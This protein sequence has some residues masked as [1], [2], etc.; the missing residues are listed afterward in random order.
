[1]RRTARLVSSLLFLVSSVGCQS[2]G[3]E[4]T[5]RKVAVGE[6]R[7]VRVNWDGLVPVADTTYELMPGPIDADRTVTVSVP[8]VTIRQ[9]DEVAIRWDST[10]PLIVVAVGGDHCVIDGLRVLDAT[11]AGD[12][13]AFNIRGGPDTTIRHC[14]ATGGQYAVSTDP[15]WP[16][17]ALTLEDVHAYIPVRRGFHVSGDPVILRGCSARSPA[18]EHCARIDGG[19]RAIVE[20]CNFELT[21]DLKAALTIRNVSGPVVVRRTRCV[22]KIPATIRDCP[23][24]LVDGSTFELRDGGGIALDFDRCAVAVV[25]HCRFNLRHGWLG[26]VHATDSATSIHGG[27]LEWSGGQDPRIQK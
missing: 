1:M 19:R 8:N 3:K 22:G 17:V 11:R 14:T 23:D 25:R 24:V 5:A 6:D 18:K 20:D 12:A 21:H 7:T 9:R 27:T 2:A 10:Y 15:R 13:S 16:N 26:R 4:S